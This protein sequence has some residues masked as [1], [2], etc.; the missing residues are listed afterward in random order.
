MGGNN[1]RFTPEQVALLRR[2][3]E[4]YQ[5]LVEMGFEA[6]KMLGI[7]THPSIS[8]HSALNK[9]MAIEMLR[10]MAVDHK[11]N[12]YHRFT[13]PQHICQKEPYGWGS[14]IIYPD[15]QPLKAIY[16]NFP[17]REGE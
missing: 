5:E 8:F 13:E 14:F 3:A 11:P 17:L 16:L 6:E 10:T 4:K 1:S 7:G 9:D 12:K 15:D 2:I